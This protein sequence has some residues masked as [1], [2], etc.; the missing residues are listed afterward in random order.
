[1]SPDVLYQ[2]VKRIQEPAER[3][4]FPLIL[5]F[6]PF[7]G[8]LQGADITDTTYSLGYYQYGDV[9]D[10]MWY[11]ATFLPNVIGSLLM[12]LPFG[13]TMV[14]MNVYCTLVICATALSVYYLL[15]RFEMPAWMNFIGL[16]LAES[17]CWCPRVILYNYLTYFFF[18]LG[19]LVL[20]RTLSRP[21]AAKRMLFLAG[22]LF[23]LNVMVRLPNV[24]EALMIV[25]LPAYG[26]WMHKKKW[27]VI[28][29]MLI[30]FSGYVTGFFIPF[31]SISLIFNREAYVGM[32]QDLFA[33]SV[34]THDYT[35][36]GMLSL[37]ADAYA[38]TF[39]HMG[40]MIPCI[41]AGVVMFL[42]MPSR[43]LWQK[44]LLYFAGSVILV[45][46][47]FRSGIFTFHYWYYDSIFQG[48]MMFIIV[49]GILFALDIAGLLHGH[50]HE[51]MLSLAAL[52]ILLATP[53]GSNNYTHPV[54]NNLFFVA[55]VTLSVA[56]RAARCARKSIR[57]HIHETW[58]IL[59]VVLFIVLLVQG[60]LFHARFAFR[61]GMED[62]TRRD[63][64]ITQIAKLRGIRT[65]AYNAERLTSLYLFLDGRGLRG[66]DAVLFGDIPGIAY[67]CDL[68]PAIF[69]TWPDLESNET[70]RFDE[71]LSAM[72]SEPLIIV[73]G[74]GTGYEM[75]ERKYNI[76][77]MYILQHEYVKIYEQHGFAVYEPKG[78]I[79]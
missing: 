35:A 17:L 60:T 13:N 69:T 22:V 52:V 47:Y 67:I 77:Q 65:S 6:Y 74:D 57:P 28:K 21:V 14:G 53:L 43:F 10:R 44:R 79:T 38:R 15:A 39:S 46:Y 78:G 49:S 27:T 58:Q 1:M 71:A 75:S 50:E 70:S 54:I 3:F 66:K 45:V 26:V 34:T 32:V 62:G 16:F 55:P 64:A 48:A 51:K 56:R 18:T 59:G 42:L 29:E 63:T 37:I 41:A 23:G 12:H 8:L 36:G 76:L 61:D 19:T 30:A 33:M 25:V 40:I 72:E 20:V 5:F 11:F 2:R 73:H 68:K 31:A 7:I 4:V 9:L 24:T